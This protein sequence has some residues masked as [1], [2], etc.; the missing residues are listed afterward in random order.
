M[1]AMPAS[2]GH[3]M[4]ASKDICFT[5]TPS[6]RDEP[7][8]P[9]RMQRPTYARRS[10]TA[11]IMDCGEGKALRPTVPHFRSRSPHLVAKSHARDKRRRSIAP[12]SFAFSATRSPPWARASSRAMAS[13]RPVLA[14]LPRVREVSAR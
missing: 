4:Q 14:P 6:S 13:P 9:Q 11:T 5:S 12:P 2:L 7:L 3:S 1:P 10:R 8:S